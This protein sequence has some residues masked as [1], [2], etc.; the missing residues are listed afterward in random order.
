MLQA[1][2]SYDLIK[3]RYSIIYIMKPALIDISRQQY[4][5][6]VWRKLHNGEVN[7]L[8]ISPNI[9]WVI[10]SRRMRWA[11]YVA[12]MGER[13]GVYRFWWGNFRERDHLGHSGVDGRIILRWISRK[14]YVGVWTGSS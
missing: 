8:Y 7:D 12:R 2:I 4:G 5:T 9:G 14:W 3:E 1:G 10:K 13:R 6:A 11:G